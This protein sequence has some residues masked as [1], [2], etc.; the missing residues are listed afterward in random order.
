MI[1]TKTRDPKKN[2]KILVKTQLST[3]PIGK[4]NNKIQGKVNVT[5]EITNKIKAKLMTFSQ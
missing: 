4:W 1:F 3:S 2:I 5:I